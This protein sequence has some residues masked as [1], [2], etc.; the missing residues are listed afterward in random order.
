MLCQSQDRREINV[1]NR[2]VQDKCQFLVSHMEQYY[3][4][5]LLL[6]ASEEDAERCFVISLD[7][8]SKACRNLAP[9]V[10]E[11]ADARIKRALVDCALRFC[12][13]VSGRVQEEAEVDIWGEKLPG[14]YSPWVAAIVQLDTFERFVFVLSV[15][16]CYSDKECSDLLH[17]R[18][19]EV[20]E[21]RA[22]ALHSVA[23]SLKNWHAHDA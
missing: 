1:D 7:T 15:L 3:S 8:W 10:P 5:V 14:N 20:A 18:L 22:H 4:L 19:E 23:S 13:P 21:S 17:C 12:G 9:I 2:T 6:T 16:E 11:A